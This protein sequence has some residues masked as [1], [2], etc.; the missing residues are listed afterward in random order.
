MGQTICGRF[1]HGPGKAMKTRR[2][3]AGSGWLLVLSLLAGGCAD[4]GG[5]VDSVPRQAEYDLA[6][7]PVE[8]IPEREKYEATLASY[9]AIQPVITPNNP[10][11]SQFRGTPYWPGDLA[12]PKD[13][14]GEEMILLAQ[15]NFEEVPRMPDYPT[16]GMLQFFIANGESGSHMWGADWDDL[17][18]QKYFRVIYHP[19][20]HLDTPLREQFPQVTGYPP[21]TGTMGMTFSTSSEV[22]NPVDYRFDEQFGVDRW[23]YFQQT[24]PGDVD[25]LN[26]YFSAT[27]PLPPAK[28][29][30]YGYFAQDDPRQQWPDQDWVILLWMDSFYVDPGHEA[31]WGD[32]GTAIFAVE[33]SHLRKRD[34][35]QVLYS[36][37]SH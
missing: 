4:E 32:A 29:G 6:S 18:S 22:I 26:S 14:D 1:S 2:T 31:L 8:L 20:V 33:R 34:F 30:G 11:K 7:F 24:D 28:I 37:D 15:I 16:A 3:K 17:R 19:E 27:Y 10:R 25:H 21:V 35:T 23:T 13:I 9:V 36:W 12:Y 5:P